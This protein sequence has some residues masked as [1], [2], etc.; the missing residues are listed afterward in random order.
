MFF[1]LIVTHK[2]PLML[3]SGSAKATVRNSKQT[4][5]PTIIYEYSMQYRLILAKEII[6]WKS[7]ANYS[8]T[9]SYCIVNN[10][11]LCHAFFFLCDIFQYNAKI[12]WIYKRYIRWKWFTSKEILH[13]F[14]KEPN[15]A[16]MFSI[17]QQLFT[18]LS[19]H[20]STLFPL[21]ASQN[22]SW[23]MI[24]SQLPPQSSMEKRSWPRFLNLLCCE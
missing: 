12:M 11:Y 3:D 17:V 7:I 9:W 22:H 5:P 13:I 18:T 21:N 4:T 20:Y 2:C 8:M 15:V 6:K 23:A 16:V 24:Q 14:V 19:P 10:L 1:S